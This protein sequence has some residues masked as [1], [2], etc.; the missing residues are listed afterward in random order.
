MT[1]CLILAAGEGSRLRPL[2]KDRPK[3]LVPLRGKPLISR[4]IDVLK[5]CTIQNIAVATGYKAEKIEAFGFPTYHNA[6][7]D[8]TNMVTSLFVA[9]SFMEEVPGDLLVSY[10]DIVYQQNNLET[11]LQTDGDIV[12]MVDDGWLDLWTVRNEDPI[13]DAETL[14]YNQHGHLIEL[15]KKPHSLSDIEGQYTGLIKINH[16]RINEFISFYDQLNPNL[17]YDGRSFEQMYLTTFLQ[18]LIDAGWQLKP[19]KVNHGWLEVD[20]VEDLKRYEQL[21]AERKLEA[22]WKPHE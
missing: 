17:Q 7:F 12:V 20:T 6:F 18:L 19:A 4:Q 3:G 16:Q 11:V 22:L 15:G 21:S 13:N 1:S 8:S 2:T 10:G 5:S 14:K 9:R